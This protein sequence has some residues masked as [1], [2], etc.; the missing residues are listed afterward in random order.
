MPGYGDNSSSFN[1]GMV[2]NRGFFNKLLR[3]LS[4]YGMDAESMVRNQVSIGINENPN[5]AQGGSYYDLFTKKVIAKLL[6]RKSIAQLDRAYEDKRKILRQY[7]IK[8]RIKDYLTEIA[9]ETVIYDTNNF[10]C[11]MEDLPEEFDEQL[12]QKYQEN[13]KRI[14]YNFGFNDGL[15]AWYY[16]KNLLIDGFIA[17]EIVYDNKQKNIVNLS[18][19]DP[20]TLVPSTD[21]TTNTLVW[22][23]YPDNPQ[24]RRIM[25]DAQII[26]ISYSNN[27]EFAE[28]SYVENLI[29]PYNQLTMLE[30]TR[31]LYNI[32]Q[33][34]IYKKFII[35][36]GGLSRQQAEQQI[37]QL[38]SEYHE[39]VTWDD[40]MGLMYI[41]GSTDIPHSK[42]F[43]F[44]SSADGTPTVEIMPSQ[45]T[46][47]NED[48]MLIWFF[49]NLKRATKIPFSRFDEETG[50]GNVYDGTAEITRDEVKFGLFISRLR[51]IFKEIIV[52]PVK[53][54][55]IMDYP[56][57]REDNL[58]QTSIKIKFNSNQLF[59]KFKQLNN[60]AKRAEIA[61]T[62]SSN[63]QDAE[64]K[65]YLHVEWIIRNVMELTE[66][67]IQENNAF[68]IKSAIGEAT[69]GG[70][71]GSMMGGGG[72]EMGAQMGGSQMGG[73]QNA[74]MGQAMGQAQA[75]AQGGGQAQSGVQS[76]G[77]GGQGEVTF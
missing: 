44:P 75:G 67:D 14:Y 42:D 12:R 39:S 20:L 70:G 77:G 32:N 46:N 76:G 29:R 26:Y 60:L 66:K 50:G 37:Y 73:P 40:R 53:I 18:A 17:Y 11:Q 2:Q 1:Q 24:L 7:S 72:G 13:F 71:G 3:S 30:Q 21:P 25:L 45:G 36:T 33:A 58:F 57:L 59:E 22:V 41:N 49:K 35:P 15:T 9:D 61:S 63:L 19:I 47:L 10:F 62:L 56:E 43:W 8:D 64:G 28:T 68:K 31:M 16:F 65:P 69:G 48:V 27:N 55:M 4:N 34:A 23:Q 5:Q 52:K 38:M 51:T 74:Q 54:Q 6:D